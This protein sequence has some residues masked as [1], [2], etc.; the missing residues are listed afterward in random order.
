MP[1]RTGRVLIGTAIALLLVVIFGRSGALFYTDTLWYGSLDQSS[2]FWTRVLTVLA[3]RVVTGLVGA[4]LIL[5]NLWYVLRQLGPV[6][7]RRR[8]GNLEIAEQVPRTYLIGGAI[9]VSVLAG[10]WL[11][12]L[13]FSGNAAVALLAW[14]RS[15]SWGVADPLFGHDLS[16]YIFSLP[17]YVR[18][19]EFLL[20]VTIWSVLLVGV[21]YALVGAVRVRGARWEID[22]R[23]RVHFAILVAALL[24]IFGMRF[25][26]GRYELMLEGSGFGTIGY[27][28][29]HARLP[30]R[31]VL[32][33][34]AFA[35]GVSLIYGALRRTWTPPVIAFGVLILAGLGMGVVYPAVVQKVQVEPN[36]LA[37]EARYIDWHMEFTRR[38][39]GLTDVER[40]SFRY[41]RADAATWAEMAPVLERLPL[42]DLPQL[43]AVFDQV[44]ARQRYYQFPDVDYDRYNAESGREQVAIA[45]REFTAEG[46]PE[47]SRTWQTVHLNP[48]ATRGLGAVVTPT[49]EKQR[50]DPV[51]WLSEVLPRQRHAGAPPGLELTEPS[52]FFGERM[53]HYVIVGHAGRFTAVSDDLA[54]ASSPVPQVSTG[55]PLSSFVRIAAF[56]LRFGEQNL[57][58]ARELGDSSRML[59][60]RAIGERVEALA[61]FLLWDADAHPV[62]LDGRIVWIM[63]GYTASGNFPL[64]FQPTTPEISGLRYLRSSVKAVIDAVTGEVAMYAVGEEDPILRTYRKIF[65][66]LIRDGDEMPAALR[67]HLRYPN[68]LFRVQAEV[69]QRYHLERAEAFYAGQDVWELPRDLPTQ[70]RQR[71]R[72]P[73]IT[74]PMPGSAQPEFLLLSPFIARERQN[75]TGIL[76]ARSDPPHYGELV[77]LEMPRDDQI[78]GP[79]QVTSIIEQDPV[80][81][82]QLSLWRQA[83]RNVERGNLRMVPTDSSILYIVPLFLSA[84]D[85]GIPQL[86]Q[87]IATDGTAVTMAADLQGAIAG[88]IG[89]AAQREPPAAATPAPVPAAPQPGELDDWRARAIDLMREAENRLRAGDFAGFGAAWT[90]LR[91]LLE[92]QPSGSF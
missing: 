18:L 16:F 25:L 12:S 51:Y 33:L 70:Q 89:D 30:A 19:L 49:A 88:L 11:S 66:S 44:E 64:S 31:A 22:D 74:A 46:L 39:Y 91:A 72:L 85:R 21:G 71:T 82:Q 53:S 67:E 75:L 77:L 40:R 42:W 56:A 32:G 61:P 8:Y 28:D 83:G 43:Q 9:G 23:P 54:R 5:L 63:D 60:R 45:V 29:V 58:F 14:L 76:A 59:F 81:S 68:M 69:L 2:V 17:T 3:V 36:E 4:A 55:I 37:R 27:T 15:E 10:W 47:D 35:A 86:Q 73:F 90:R 84:Q 50:G 13:Q 26:L 65:P 1:R 34:L 6:H 7:L 20:I 79:S 87:V 57:L 78:R 92:Q 80:I 41:R 24:I 62:V 48:S 38:A 52:V